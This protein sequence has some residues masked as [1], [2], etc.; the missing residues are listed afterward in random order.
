MT[1]YDLQAGQLDSIATV[2]TDDP[3]HELGAADLR[4]AS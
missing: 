2:Q 3:E 4:A 1:Y